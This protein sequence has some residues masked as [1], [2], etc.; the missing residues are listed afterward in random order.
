L[1]FSGISQAQVMEV[2]CGDLSEADCAFLQTAQ[3][4]MMTMNA[5][6]FELD[7]QLT[8]EGIPGMPGGGATV[9][10]AGEGAFAGEAMSAMQP[11]PAVIAN[12]MSDPEA[13]AAFVTEAL[14]SFDGQL[15]LVISI[16]ESLSGGAVPSEIP[17]NLVLVDGIGYIDFDSLSVALGPEM[18]GVLPAGWGGL[19]LGEV[20]STAVAQSGAFDASGMVD[21]DAMSPFMD[22]AFLEQF[23]F[24]E[25]LPD[26][27]SADGANVAVFQ[28]EIDYGALLNSAEM[29]DMIMGMATA[30]GGEI[31]ESEMA[32]MDAIFGA[33]GDSV[34]LV[35]VQTIGLD[36]NLMR[37]FDILLDI[38]T[39]AV[40]DAL[41]EDADG[42]APFFAV[43]YSV[44]LSNHNGGQ[45]I[46]A[47]AGA[48]IATLQD[49]MNFGAPPS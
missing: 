4:A 20:I 27:V 22:I 15:D 40:M 39:S 17:L 43:T 8:L 34:S 41:G 19:N 47:P 31:T 46:E 42:D 21:A 36:D 18:A 30:Q 35:V 6:D 5:A 45:V 24:I 10:V 23:M 29:R 13:Y 12:M 9:G 37:S 1:A 28:I 3:D 38:D 33:L 49:L 25:R 2:P 14:Q 7:F 48:N 26:E 16:P 44:A 11:D 32:E